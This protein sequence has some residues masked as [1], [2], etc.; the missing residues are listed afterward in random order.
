MEDNGR[1]SNLLALSTS[2]QNSRHD[3]SFTYCVHIHGGEVGLEVLGVVAVVFYQM[4]SELLKT[5]CGISY[6]PPPNIYFLMFTHFYYGL[7]ILQSSFAVRLL[8][9]AHWASTVCIFRCTR[10]IEWLLDVY[11][12]RCINN[13]THEQKG[14]FNNE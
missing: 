11:S 10:L 5:I 2:R 12:C 14:V 8:F 13:E 6:P 4:A 9:M 7:L 3:I 1:I